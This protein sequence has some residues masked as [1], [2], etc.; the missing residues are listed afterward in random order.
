LK[1]KITILIVFII[2]ATLAFIYKDTFLSQDFLFNT[3]KS[4]GPWA[5]IVF[6]LLYIIGSAAFFPASFITLLSGLLFG[7]K[8]GTIYAVIGTVLGASFCFVIARYLA[9]DWLKKKPHPIIATVQEGVKQD[10]WRYLAIMRL[11]PISPFSILNYAFGLTPMKLSVFALTT[12]F[13]TIPMTFTYAY[14]GFLGRETATEQ[15]G[16]FIKIGI[17]LA[18]L[19]L[20]SFL[21]RFFRKKVK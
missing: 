11:V 7:L 2:L 13:A 15:G 1:R 16:S 20:L 17:G 6:C 8:M 3:I 19:I 4:F 14:I 18:L 21:P 5:P 9:G 12:S 10:G